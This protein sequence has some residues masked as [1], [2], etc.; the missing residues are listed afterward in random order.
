THRME[1][2]E[3]IC[4]KIVLVNKGKKILDGSVKNVKQE[5]KEHIF[6]IVLDTSNPVL[7]SGLQLLKQ[8]GNTLSFKLEE[9]QN[10]NTILQH[11]LQQGNQV[12]SFQ[13]ILPSLNDIFIGL[14]QG[15]SAAREFIQVD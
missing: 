1:Q 14:V 3:E 8:E 15:T 11:F 6:K 2:V 13:E 10:S 9:S 7:P 12:Q 5:F 4:D